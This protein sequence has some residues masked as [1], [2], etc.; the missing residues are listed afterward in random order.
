[1]I[2]FIESATVWKIGTMKFAAVPKKAAPSD[3]GTTTVY[4]A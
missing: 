3:G 1:M 2:C 4:T